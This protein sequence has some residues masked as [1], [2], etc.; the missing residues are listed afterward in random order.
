MSRSYI[1]PGDVLN[2][3]VAPGGGVTAGTGVLISNQFVIPQTTA[4]ATFTFDGYVTG[5]HSH[6]KIG[7]Q[8]WAVGDVVYWDDTNKWFTKTATAGFYGAGGVFTAMVATGAGAG[9]TTGVVR[10][11]GNPVFTVSAAYVAR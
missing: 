9:E 5:V 2:A 6:A 7:S 3:L 8:A 11:S 1:Q 10:L 4:A